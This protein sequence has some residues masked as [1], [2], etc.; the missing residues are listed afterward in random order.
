V[1]DEHYRPRAEGQPPQAGGSPDMIGDHRREPER[2]A[3]YHV[4]LRH[5]LGYAGDALPAGRGA[6]R[7]T[8]DGARRACRTI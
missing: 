8:D 7:E 5:L 6:G 4:F 1:E 3:L 2:G